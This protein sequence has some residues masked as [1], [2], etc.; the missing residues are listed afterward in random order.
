MKQLV[1]ILFLSLFCTVRMQAQQ[2]AVG[3]DLML[4]LLQTPNIGAEMV[5]GERATIGLNVFG[6]YKPWGKDMKML[7]VQPEVRYWFGG[8]PMHKYFVGVGAIGA[9]YDITWK[10]KIY[11]GTALGAGITF[12]YVFNITNRLNIDAHAG[13]GIISYKHKE[14]HQYDNYYDYTHGGV[15]ETNATGNYL[16]P[17]R[18]GVSLTYILK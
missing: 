4:D 12:G 16:L 6:N 15:I 2:L 10:G 8:R 7:G 13:F 5:V 18:I 14:Y 9:S 11:D 1:S 17:T 3:T